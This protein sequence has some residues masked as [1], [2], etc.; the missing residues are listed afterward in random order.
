MEAPASLA[1]TQPEAAAV[2]VPLVVAVPGTP[3][4]DPVVPAEQPGPAHSAVA[5]DSAIAAGAP[6]TGLLATSAAWAKALWASC[7]A[8]DASAA[9]FFCSGV[10]P[11]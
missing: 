8:E 3:E 4:V 2:Q 11:G 9:A 10:A 5:D 7:A 1:A 6:V